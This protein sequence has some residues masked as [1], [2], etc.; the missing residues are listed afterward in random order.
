MFISYR[1]LLDLAG[2][3]CLILLALAFITS[4]RPDLIASAACLANSRS[5]LNLDSFSWIGQIADLVHN[6]SESQPRSVLR[7]LPSYF[8]VNYRLNWLA[9]HKIQGWSSAL[10]LSK[11]PGLNVCSSWIDFHVNKLLYKLCKVNS[12]HM[13]M[14]PSSLWEYWNVLQPQN[15]NVWE[16]ER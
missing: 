7:I 16:I 11:S 4:Y 2:L 14:I 6:C 12:M 3:S 15:R 1:Y 8:L 5:W 13:L 9:R 10:E